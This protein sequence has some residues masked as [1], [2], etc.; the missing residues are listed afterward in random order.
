MSNILLQFYISVHSF[1]HGDTS[2]FVSY[3]CVTAAFGRVVLL[4]DFFFF[5][6]LRFY[7][8]PF[9]LKLIISVF[10]FVASCR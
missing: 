5:L 9:Y 4:K 6:L 1:V 8:F 2:I 3:S 10:N 7:Y